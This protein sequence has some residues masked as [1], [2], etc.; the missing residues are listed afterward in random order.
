VLYG[1][2]CIVFAAGAGPSFGSIYTVRPSGTGLRKLFQES[3][4]IALQPTWAPSGDR[5]LFA[6]IDFATGGEDLYSIRP[7]GSGLT[8][9]TNTPD[10]FEDSPDWGTF[11]G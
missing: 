5:I 8:Q 9:V 4:E 6:L 11:S 10:E 3:G 1:P 2:S 7:D